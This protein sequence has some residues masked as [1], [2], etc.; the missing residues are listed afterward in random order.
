MIT[1]YL[2]AEFDEMTADVGQELKDTARRIYVRSLQIFLVFAALEIICVVAIGASA[3][4]TDITPFGWFVAAAVAVLIEFFILQGIRHIATLKL[5]AKGEMVHL[6]KN[7]GVGEEKRKAVYSP[8]PDT[9]TKVENNAV[10]VTEVW[11]CAF[12]GSKNADNF[13]ARCGKSKEESQEARE[14][15]VCSKCNTLNSLKYSQCKNC[16]ALR[17][18]TDAAAW[19]NTTKTLIADTWKCDNCGARNSN[20]YGQC[21]KC[22]TYR[23]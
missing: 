4:D 20:N 1:E 9:Q 3:D 19:E 6:L 16:A 15:W 21:K 23:A 2:N 14:S 11:E 5:Y 18:S 7:N 17:N 10:P 8:M 12:C 22:G 13:C